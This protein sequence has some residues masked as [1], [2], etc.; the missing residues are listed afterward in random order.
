MRWLLTEPTTQLAWVICSVLPSPVWHRL[1]S[2][3]KRLSSHASELSLRVNFLLRALMPL[4]SKETSNHHSVGE[5]IRTVNN[6]HTVFPGTVCV[7]ISQDVT[8]AARRAPWRCAAVMDGRCRSRATRRLQTDWA[9]DALAGFH[10]GTRSSLARNW[11]F[12][13]YS[14]YESVAVYSIWRRIRARVVRAVISALSVLG[15]NLVT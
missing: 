1:L 11:R 14:A 8:E 5:D 2:S 9:S 10:G 3:E 6:G 12:I 4:T 13:E 15:H 7:A